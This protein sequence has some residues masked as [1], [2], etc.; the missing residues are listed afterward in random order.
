MEKKSNIIQ[1]GILGVLII[2]AFLLGA[3]LEKK[4]TTAV[5]PTDTQQVADTQVDT[6][7]SETNESIASRLG[8]N[9]DEFTSC[10]ASADITT[11][12]ENQI[13][14]GSKSGVSGTPGSF[15]IDTQT[16]LAVELGGAVPLATLKSDFASLKSGTGT[17]LVIDPVTSEDFVK[18]NASSRYTLIVWSDFDCPYCKTFH[19]TAE[20]FIAENADVKL[21]Y[22][23]FPLDFHPNAKGKAIAALCAG[24]IGGND[25]F[26]SFA[27]E[28]MKQE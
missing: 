23:Q 28:L 5:I 12:V 2:I 14:S 20:S 18:G 9:A 13:A 27:S 19:A 24:K 4:P 10:I 8:L 25:M 16:G 3:L 1:L 17:K 7:P 6:V 22:R 21:V 26:W 11:K 15:L